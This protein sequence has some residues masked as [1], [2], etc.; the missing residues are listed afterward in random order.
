[1]DGRVDRRDAV[2]G[3]EHDL[4]SRVSKKVDEV[5]DDG[6]DLLAGPCAMRGCVRAEALQVVIEMRQV[7][8]IQ[9]GCIFVFDPFGGFRDPARDGI[10]APCGVST[11]A[12]GPQKVGKGKFAEVAFDFRADGIG[13]GVDVE[14]LS[15]HRRDTSGAG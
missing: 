13:P 7:N 14:K 3:E 4:T 9:R 2:F 1:M 10:G 6:V 15:G 8:Q 11:P 5:A 12:A